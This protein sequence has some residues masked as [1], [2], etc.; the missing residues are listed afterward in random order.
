MLF[1][2]QM[3]LVFTNNYI[4]RRVN[5]ICPV[6]SAIYNLPDGHFIAR[7]ESILL[8]LLLKSLGSDR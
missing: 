5:N 6:F 3:Y 1:R 7:Y 2:V 8:L 4:L